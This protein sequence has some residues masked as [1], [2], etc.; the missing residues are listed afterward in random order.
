[1]AVRMMV[2][3]GRTAGICPLFIESLLLLLYARIGSPRIAFR[4]VVFSCSLL[5]RQQR[6]ITPFIPP[7]A[8]PTGLWLQLVFRVLCNMTKSHPQPTT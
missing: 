6:V 2:R 4:R 3:M 7:H 1:M 8:D 5:L